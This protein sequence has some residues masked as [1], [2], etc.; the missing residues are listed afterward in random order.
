MKRTITVVLLILL[1]L[2]LAAGGFLVYRYQNTHVR[3]ADIYYSRELRSLDLRGVRLSAEDYD[4]VRD[5]MPECDIAWNVPF[6]GGYYPSD[7]TTLVITSLT[8]ADVDALDYMTG[9]RKV[10]AVGCRDYDQ[11]LELQKRHPTCKVYYD[12][13]LGEERFNESARDITVTALTQ[14]DIPLLQYLPKLWRVHLVNPKADAETVFGLKALY[15]NVRFTWEY[16]VRNLTITQRDTEADFS[17]MSVSLARVKRASSYFPDL[18]KVIMSDCGYDNETMA[19]FREELREQCKVVWTVD[20][21]GIPVRTDET[22]FIPIKHHVYYFHDEDVYNLRY[23]ED[24]IAVDL[25]HMTFH[26]LEWVEFMPNL[27]YLILAHTTVT[28]ISSLATCKNLVFLEMDWT[29][30]R[31]YEPLLGCT[32]LE[33]LN[34]GLT[35]GD[36]EIIGQMTWLKNLWWKGRGHKALNYLMEKLP[37]TTLMFNPP[38]TVGNGWRKLQNYYDMRDALGMYYMEG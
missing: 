2:G 7:T 6:Q 29:G 10:N 3:V 19:D 23:C 13:E 33:D 1:L 24:M 11:L 28:D 17:G 18:E 4:A 31:D 22:S 30:I 12:L 38:I 21:G 9:L 5:K 15:P 37:N 14:K 20:C 16:R 34:L 25:G 8:D 27:K 32:A 26:D 36:Y 35:Y